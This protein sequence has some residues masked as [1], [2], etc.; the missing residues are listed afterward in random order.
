L[1][2][3]TRTDL[4]VEPL[5]GAFSKYLNM[6]ETA[7]LLALVKSVAP[8]VMIEFGCNQGITAKRMLENLP[9]L[10][11]YIGI[12]VPFGHC[13]TLP[14]QQTETPV[15]AGWYAADDERFFYLETRSQMLRTG[16]L[17]PCDA[18]FID[19]DHSEHAVLHESRLA[20]RLVRAPGLIAWHDYSN[21]AVEVTRALDQLVYDGWPINCVEG[22]WLAFMR[23]EKNLCR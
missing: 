20:R 8:R 18:V 10:E 16:H 15:N 6:H 19:G 9:T 4:G 13:A 14:C 17:E 12:D 1:R 7:I 21:P 23:V 22:S 5:S 11:R 3:F 2:K